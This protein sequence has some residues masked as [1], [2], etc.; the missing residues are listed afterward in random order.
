MCDPIDFLDVRA[1]QLAIADARFAPRAPLR[2]LGLQALRLAG[3]KHICDG[4]RD[5][6]IPRQLAVRDGRVVRARARQLRACERHR[7]IALPRDGVDE[8]VPPRVTRA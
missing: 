1:P 4:V 3:A 8:L 6:G 7:A 2:P 5:D